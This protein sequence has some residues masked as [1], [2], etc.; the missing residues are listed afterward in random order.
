MA[1]YRRLIIVTEL[2]SLEIP[3]ERFVDDLGVDQA[4]KIGLSPDRIFPPLLEG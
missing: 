1:S 3:P 4:L 2:W